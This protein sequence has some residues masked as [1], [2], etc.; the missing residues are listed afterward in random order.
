MKTDSNGLPLP[1]RDLDLEIARILGIEIVQY[2]RDA[3]ET[4]YILD[5]HSMGP[6]LCGEN[7]TVPWT[8]STT[9]A[10]FQVMEAAD[11]EEVGI[12]ESEGFV[13]VTLWDTSFPCGH[14]PKYEVMV[15]VSD[16]PSRLEAYAHAVCACAWKAAQ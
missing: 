16:Y 11:L 8:P 9:A 6:W 10:F 15:R 1:G 4:P 3:T 14:W 5:S 7:Y 2:H 12:T 13:S